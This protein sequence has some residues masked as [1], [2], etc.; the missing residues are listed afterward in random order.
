NASDGWYVKWTHNYDLADDYGSLYVD[1]Y[2]RRGLGVGVRHVYEDTVRYRGELY[3]YSVGNPRGGRDY[4]AEWNQQWRL[5]TG[6]DGR[7][8][9]GYERLAA[10]T[11]ASDQI[12]RAEGSFHQDS[13]RSFLEL[14]G[15]YHTEQRSQRDHI[16]E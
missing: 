12:W 3:G 2:Q 8:K 4:E 9:L 15:K 7:L 5:G 11:P 10:G 1:Y 14:V 13:S 6:L 16:I